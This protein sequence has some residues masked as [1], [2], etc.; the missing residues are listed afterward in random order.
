MEDK[1]QHSSEPNPDRLPSIS[2][3]EKRSPTSAELDLLYDSEYFRTSYGSDGYTPTTVDWAGWL[4]IILQFKPTGRFCDLGCAH[5]Y[6]VDLARQAG[7]Q[8]VGAD[9]SFFALKQLSDMAPFL[10]Q[11]DLAHL[12]FQEQSFDVVAVFDVLEHVTQG[13]RA[14]AEAARLLKPDGL[15]IG[16]TPDP[17]FFDRD[18]R[19]HCFERPPSF[20]VNLFEQWGFKVAFRFS[21][22]YQFQFV[23]HRLDS[24]FGP[25]AIDHFQHDYFGSES[26]FVRG[27]GLTAMPRMGWKPLSNRSRRLAGREAS[28]YLLKSD[29][30]PCGLRIRFELKNPEGEFGTLRV[31]LDGFLLREIF[32]DSEQPEIEFVVKEIPLCRGGHNL[33]FHLQPAERS[34]QIHNIEIECSQMDRRSLVESLP[35]DLYQR[36]ELAS[37]VVE[38]L[39][40][41]SVLDVGGVLGDESGHL[42]ASSDFFPHVEHLGTTDLRPVDLPEHIQADGSQLPFSDC[43]FEIVLSLD[44]LEHLPASKR[45]QFLLELD[46]IAK[47]WVLV[48]FPVQTPEVEE[49]E[50][51]LKA[52]LLKAHG[53]LNEHSEFGLPH[54]DLIEGFA[55]KHSRTLLSF[56]SGYL[57]HWIAMQALT[58]RFLQA[59]TSDEMRSLN[60]LYN[61]RFLETDWQTPAYRRLFLLGRK[62]LP[63]AAMEHFQ[64]TLAPAT[65]AGPSLARSLFSDAEYLRLEES[66]LVQAGAHRRALSAVQFLAGERQEEISLLHQEVGYLKSELA[67]TPLW[68]LGKQRL[69]KKWND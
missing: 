34:I 41:R 67:D 7:F 69:S 30:K 63:E 25:V 58:H 19:T 22:N 14:L 26:E 59:G 11:T 18:E 45:E 50:H 46:R 27:H 57:P 53:F 5:G 12:P 35:F 20:W 9:I 28:I 47:N 33:A 40:G 61:R 32:F 23:A 13:D 37:R 1:I 4:E 15:I 3:S 49:A 2:P 21:G 17:V 36:Y 24:A 62:S 31:A 42:A 8:A 6:L 29:R 64:R 51:H 60:R 68:K 56:S 16:S 43:Q 39:E 10:A 44:V 48:G 38:G 55:R 54:K 66:L 65:E 52:S